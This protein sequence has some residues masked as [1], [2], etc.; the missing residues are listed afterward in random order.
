MVPS[1]LLIP[2]FRLVIMHEQVTG[3][4]QMLF[5]VYGKD[6]NGI[7]KLKIIWSFGSVVVL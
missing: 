1:L 4:G 3:I 6:K 7:P 5:I 2:L